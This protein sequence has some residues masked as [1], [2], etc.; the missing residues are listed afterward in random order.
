MASSRSRD[1]A[2]EEKSARS[3]NKTP[4]TLNRRPDTAIMNKLMFEQQAILIKPNIDASDKELHLKNKFN[5]QSK[6]MEQFIQAAYK[7][8]D[9]VK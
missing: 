9:F 6:N 4:R 7:D 2:H 8:S 3:K 1:S 5:Y